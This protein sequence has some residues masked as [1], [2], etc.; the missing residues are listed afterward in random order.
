MVIRHE[1]PAPVPDPAAGAARSGDRHH[2]RQVR[3]GARLQPE[4]LPRAGRPGRGQ[5][6]GAAGGRPQERHRGRAVQLAAPPQPT[7]LPSL[8]GQD[9]SAQGKTLNEVPSNQN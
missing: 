9:S 3:E 1:H 7:T 2:L 6:G 4:A 5:H 8:A